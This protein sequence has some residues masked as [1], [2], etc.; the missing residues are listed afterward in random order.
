M[1]SFAGV[2]V[3]LLL[4]MA[5]FAQGNPGPFGGLFGRT[6]E[7]VGKEYR[8]FEIRT[9]ATGQYEG[10][11]NDTSVPAGEPLRSG[12]SGTA[13]LSGRFEHRS[14]RLEF[15]A[16]S[17]SSYLQYLEAPYHGGTSVESAARVAFRPATRLN[18]EA[19]VSHA[20][21]PFFQFHPNFFSWMPDGALVAPSSPF[22]ATAL[23][24]HSTSATAGFMVPYS[25]RSTFGASVERRETWFRKHPD[26]DLSTLGMRG[27]WS[28]QLN[29]DMQLRLGYGRDRVQ[30]R[31][32]DERLYETIDVGI[33]YLRPF[34]PGRRMSFAIHTQTA[35]LSTPEFGGTY[36][37]NGGLTVM[38]RFHRTWL[39]DLHAERGTEFI[40]GFLEPLNT[41]TAG[42]GISGMLSRRAE[43]VL[44]AN[45]GRGRF[46]FDTSLARSVMGMTRAQFSYAIARRLGMFL[47]HALFY[48]EL[49]QSASP[50][51]P[52]TYLARQVITVGMTTWIPIYTRERSPSDT[53]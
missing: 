6:P 23:E 33:N 10:G 39:L 43:L 19:T 25:K 51:A 22:V 18:L 28:R 26:L 4:P 34:S 38:R 12:G 45:G 20:Y 16:Y 27:S 32:G 24:S 50:I 17:Y 5:A 49:P 35:K 44:Q 48:Y 47:Q 13:A 9:A 37:L 30:L 41:D 40:A 36:R 3:L 42:A 1:K 53:R 2:A 8:L 7:R 46:G 52:V 31:A 14:S 21:R 11:L 15:A 29:R